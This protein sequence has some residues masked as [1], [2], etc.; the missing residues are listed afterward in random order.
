M[1]FSLPSTKQSCRKR[2]VQ[3][4]PR[5][6]GVGF[7]NRRRA[8]F[9]HASTGGTPELAFARIVARSVNDHRGKHEII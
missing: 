7:W 6:L 3:K 2:I 5:F 1:R 8:I 9:S 4:A